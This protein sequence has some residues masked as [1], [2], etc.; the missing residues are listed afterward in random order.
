MWDT[1]MV[2]LLTSI[3]IALGIFLI[4]CFIVEFMAMTDD[5]DE[6][7]QDMLEDEDD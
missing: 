3:T 5:C 6:A 7:V 2:T 1:F 4:G